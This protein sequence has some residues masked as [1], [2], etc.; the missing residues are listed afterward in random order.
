MSCI[1]VPVLHRRA[2]AALTCSV[3][4]SLFA[5]MQTK[6][7]EEQRL[8]SEMDALETQQQITKRKAEVFAAAEKIEADSAHELAVHRSVASESVCVCESSVFAQAGT[9]AEK[10]QAG[11]S[12]PKP[13]KGVCCLPLACLLTCHSVSVSLSLCLGAQNYLRLGSQ[14]LVHQVSQDKLAA[15]ARNQ[16]LVHQVHAAADFRLQLGQLLGCRLSRTC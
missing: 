14:K 15:E 10:R 9:A 11:S 12:L 2:C 5:N 8:T 6:Y 4:G 1:D 13:G 7:R 3:A 16:Q